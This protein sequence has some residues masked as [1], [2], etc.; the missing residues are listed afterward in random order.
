MPHAGT[1]AG[2]LEHSASRAEIIA[3]A[4]PSTC[5]RNEA[6]PSFVAQSVRR[7]KGY[8]WDH[9]KQTF[10]P[11]EGPSPPRPSGAFHQEQ[12]HARD[13]T[14]CCWFSPPISRD[15]RSFRSGGGNYFKLAKVGPR[16]FKMGEWVCFEDDDDGGSGGDSDDANRADPSEQEV[17]P[18]ESTAPA[19]VSA[20]SP[21]RPLSVGQIT[22][23]WEGF[24]QSV[25][26][27]RWVE[28][29]R[30]RPIAACSQ[31]AVAAFVEKQQPGQGQPGGRGGGAGGGGGARSLPLSGTE[32]ALTR[33]FDVFPLQRLKGHAR[34]DFEPPP[35]E[36]MAPLRRGAGAGGGGGGGGGGAGPLGTY[37]CRTVVL[38]D[39]DEGDNDDDDDDDGQRLAWLDQVRC[40][41]LIL[42][43]PQLHRRSTFVQR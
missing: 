23:M 3:A 40:C 38:E 42:P 30:L 8:L 18:S 16:L 33:E 17:A 4:A 22:C 14:G 29:R 31:R 9:V 43:L 24:P 19:S 36:A 28:I 39:N 5:T 21:A 6:V 27:S 13:N 12:P 32:V 20:S 34:V 15:S 41:E 26:M 10:V 25:L 37:K 35:V 2:P 11:T 1:S 7:A